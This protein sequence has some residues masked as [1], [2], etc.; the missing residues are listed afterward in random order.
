M[1]TSFSAMVASWEGVKEEG[2]IDWRRVMVVVMRVWRAEKVVSSSA[3]TW[4]RWG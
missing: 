3:R 4:R 2:E 1:M